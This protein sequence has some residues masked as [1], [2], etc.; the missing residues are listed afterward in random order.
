MSSS[1][2]ISIIMAGGLG[3]RM[4]S[5]TPKVLLSVQ[6]RPMIIHVLEKAL[7]ISE[8]Y[9]I[10]VVGRYETEIRNCIETYMNT[11]QKHKIHYIKQ[12]EGVTNGEPHS[13]GTGDAL[14]CC[15]PFLEEI[16]QNAKVVVLSGDV[17]MITT[18]LL[19]KFSSY[20]NAL[21][22]SESRDPT[23]YGR[24]FINADGTFT[25]R[26]HKF[27]QEHMLFYKY[28]NVGLYIFSIAFLSKH[29]NTLQVNSSGEIFLTDL[30][31]Q[32]FMYWRDFS[33]FTNVNTMDELTQLN[34][35]AVS[36]TD[37]IFM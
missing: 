16:G 1:N 5:E 14:K 3:K 4:K 26:E 35:T 23:G 15:M 10:V 33:L 2:I 37:C 12:Q 17:P 20:E 8:H 28:V 31:F 36:I 9:V 7:E 32:Q 18:E 34:H 13:M 27:C 29:M 11:S 19:E 22:V 30:P 24:V 6:N 25:V 21:I